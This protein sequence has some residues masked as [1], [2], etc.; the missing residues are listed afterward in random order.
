MAERDLLEGQ[1][2][3]LDFKV[4]DFGEAGG[5]F[6]MI[7]CGRA[8]SFFRIDQHEL[9]RA[10]SQVI[11]VPKP[12]VVFKPMR[13]DLIAKDPPRTRIGARHAL[14]RGLF[15]GGGG[16]FVDYLGAKGARARPEEREVKQPETADRSPVF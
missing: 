5:K 4:S 15:L 11:A 7:K 9:L 16:F 2:V 3:G 13:S 1:V 8:D 12:A 14:R 10:L 6:L